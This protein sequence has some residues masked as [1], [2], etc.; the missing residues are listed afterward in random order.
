MGGS[1]GP[2]EPQ[3]WETL[4]SCSC[5]GPVG[6]RVHSF[7]KGI[8]PEQPSLP[9]LPLPGHTEQRRASNLLAAICGPGG[10]PDHKALRWR[11]GLLMGWRL[12]V[13]LQGLAVDH[14]SQLWA[15]VYWGGC[16]SAAGTHNDHACLVSS[17]QD[18]LRGDPV[19]DMPREQMHTALLSPH[20]SQRQ[21]VL[22]TGLLSRHNSRIPPL[23]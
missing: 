18:S 16:Q 10:I 14:V 6:E 15:Q 4:R 7:S 23:G 2:P 22:G 20:A 1:W 8:P 21:G 9:V 17:N 3:S 13:Q 12:H 5:Q 19:P 11:F